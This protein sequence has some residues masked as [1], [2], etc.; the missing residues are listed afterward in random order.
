MIGRE[1]IT[2]LD[3]GE[4]FVRARGYVGQYCEDCHDG[5]DRDA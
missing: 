4:R 5:G 3:C 1:G 2:C